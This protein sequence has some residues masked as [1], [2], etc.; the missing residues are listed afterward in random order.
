MGE[1]FS[2]KCAKCQQSTCYAMKPADNYLA[3]LCLSTE[4][5]YEMLQVHRQKG[6]EME[7]EEE[8]TADNDETV[9]MD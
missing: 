5:L 9:I 2:H 7:E 4:C 6:T 3:P 8:T 1:M